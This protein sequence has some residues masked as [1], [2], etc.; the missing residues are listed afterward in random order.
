[1]KKT[2]FI[3]LPVYRVA[4]LLM[5]ILCAGDVAAEIYRCEGEDGS[6]IFSD[7]PCPG[8]GEIVRPDVRVTEWV[9]P[10]WKGGQP[11]IAS[12]RSRAA[13]SKAALAQAEREALKQEQACERARSAVER[14]H[15][16]RRKGYS[17]KQ[18]ERLRRQLREKE[19]YIRDHCR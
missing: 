15:R 8:G 7:S 5:F 13:R 14:I 10:E 9:A 18:G 3:G 11:A 4:L 16:Q 17:V 19:A 6:I 2:V 12:D 1:M